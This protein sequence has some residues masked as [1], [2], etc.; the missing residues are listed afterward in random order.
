MTRFLLFFIIG[1]MVTQQLNA[2]EIS[3]IN[4]LNAEE[5]PGKKFSVD[6]MVR[7]RMSKSELQSAARALDFLISAI[8]RRHGDRRY[9]RIFITWYL[10][11]MKI[12]AG[13]WATTHFE[14]K[15]TVN[16]MDWMLE[17]NPTTLKE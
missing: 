3:D 2:V 10:P 15:L 16:I 9:P 8:Q 17:Y 13:A 1:F 12:G 4:L 7:K 6:V 5:L 14:P 11:G